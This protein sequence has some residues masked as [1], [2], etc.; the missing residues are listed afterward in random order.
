MTTPDHAEPPP[1]PQREILPDHRAM[2]RFYL[3]D[4]DWYRQRFPNVF[5]KTTQRLPMRA[6]LDIERT[7]DD[8]AL[9]V[10]L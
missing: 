10:S 6:S 9:G 8:S 7:T 1:R 2:D 5:I 4:L 3:T